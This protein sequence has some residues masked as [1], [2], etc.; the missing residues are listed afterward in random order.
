LAPVIK[1]DGICIP[2]NQRALLHHLHWIIVRAALDPLLLD[3]FPFLSRVK[4]LEK[5]AFD[6]RIY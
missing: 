5:A 6:R 3:E 1:T 4:L 2:H